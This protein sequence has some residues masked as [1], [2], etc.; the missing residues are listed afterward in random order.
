MSMFFTGASRLRSWLV[1]VSA[2]E[3]RCP[4]LVAGRGA[5]KRHA[6]PRVRQ[7]E[8]HQ[9]EEEQGEFKSKW[10]SKGQQNERG[11]ERGGKKTRKLRTMWAERRRCVWVERGG[12]GGNAGRRRG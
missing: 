6:S 9:E 2:H 11:G 5:E 8:S 10:R 4:F 1:L 7:A 12:R 3:R